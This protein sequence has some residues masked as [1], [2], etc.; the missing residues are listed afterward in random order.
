MRPEMRAGRRQRREW[1]AGTAGRAWELFIVVWDTKA[2]SGRVL[3][4]II[5]YRSTASQPIE[6]RED[7]CG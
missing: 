5:L 2:Q 1:R 4:A 7:K 6:P 3:P